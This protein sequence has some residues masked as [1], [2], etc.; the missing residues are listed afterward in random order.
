MLKALEKKPDDR[1]PDARSMG[2][3]LAACD[4]AATWDADQ[5]DRWWNQAEASGG[6]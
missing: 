3:A 4:A 1:Y 5:A 6:E 2:R